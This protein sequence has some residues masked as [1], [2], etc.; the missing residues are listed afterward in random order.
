MTAMNKFIQYLKEVRSEL[1]KVSWPTRNE[2]TGAT[3]LVIVL[4]LAV[5]IFVK[6][7]DWVLSSVLNLLLNM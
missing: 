1:I 7:C 6:L 4:S 3:T 5:A 2:V